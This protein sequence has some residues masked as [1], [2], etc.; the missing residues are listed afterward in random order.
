MHIAVVFQFDGNGTPSAVTEVEG[1]IADVLLPETGDT[2]SHTDLYGK[3]FEGE[4]LKRHFDYSLDDGM[5]VG[6]SITVTL[7]LKRLADSVVH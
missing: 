5:D 4:V 1:Q 6:G 7:L 2:I 3:R